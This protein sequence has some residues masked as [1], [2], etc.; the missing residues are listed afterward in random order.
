MEKLDDFILSL[1]D[2]EK[3]EAEKQKSSRK[4]ISDSEDEAGYSDEVGIEDE[5]EL[6]DVDEYGPDLYKNE[7]DRRKLEALPEVQRERILAERSEERQRN[8]ERLEVRKLLKYGRREDTTRR[9]TRSK[10][11]GTSHALN[12]LARRREEKNKTQRKRHRDTPSPERKKHRRSGYGDS[13]DYSEDE[14]S[15]EETEKRAKKRTPTLDEVVNVSVTR[16]MIEKWLY[17]PFFEDTVI[18]RRQSN[19]R[20]STPSQK[21][22]MAQNGTHGTTIS[23]EV[24]ET[25]ET[26]YHAID[27]YYYYKEK[28][29]I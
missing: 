24:A 16:H 6:E 11:A 23:M 28:K 10:G 3:K 17:A 5:E 18:A 4:Y 22:E 26:R 29:I 1:T 9:S 25:Y 27:N 2:K 20:R 7:E 14:R 15:E 13:E 21:A 12:E 19:A 8:L